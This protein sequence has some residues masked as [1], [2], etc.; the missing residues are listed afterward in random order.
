MNC[1][2]EKL[3]IEGN[4]LLICYRHWFWLQQCVSERRSIINEQCDSLINEVE[5]KREFFLSDLEYEEK[6]KSDSLTQQIEGCQQQAT[7]LHSLIHCT[8]EVLQET[9]HCSFIQVNM[10]NNLYLFNGNFKFIL[11][12]HIWICVSFLFWMDLFL[13]GSVSVSVFWWA[14]E[15]P[16]CLLYFARTSFILCFSACKINQRQVSIYFEFCSFN[17]QVFYLIF[18]CNSSHL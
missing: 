6:S 16:T 7:S 3:L 4:I 9:D 15:Q 12:V 11:S 1:H 5:T 18:W 14:F 8:K 10:M 17:I 2:I 13:N